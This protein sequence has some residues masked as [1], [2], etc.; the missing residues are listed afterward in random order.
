MKV[1]ESSILVLFIFILFIIWGCGGK[2]YQDMGI[3]NPSKLI[4]LED[5]LSQSGLSTSLINSLVLAH[6]TLG[7]QAI[8]N[9]ELEKAKYHFDRALKLLPQDTTSLYKSF[10]VKGHILYKTGNKNKL[11]DSIQAYHNAA[12][13]QKSFGEPYY[14]IG[15][16][17]YKIGDKDFDLIIESYDKA[18]ELD[19]SSKIRELVNKERLSALDRNHRLKDFWK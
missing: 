6:N 11:W 10:L 19:L 5:S 17:Y 4:S 3:N 16:A 12:S 9:G 7:D 8:I 15:L 18:L 14:Y 2:I 13:I 1:K